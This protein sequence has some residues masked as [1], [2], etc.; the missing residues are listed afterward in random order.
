MFKNIFCE[1]HIQTS[2]TLEYNYLNILDLSANVI[3]STL[4]KFSGGV[5]APNGN[6][7]C[8][9]YNATYIAVVDKITKL[10]STP[11]INLFGSEKFIGGVLAPNGNIY[12]IPYNSDKIL[13]INTRDNTHSFIEGITTSNY[14]SIVNDSQKWCGG[15][16]YND[17]IYCIPFNAECFMIINTTN[18]TV[19]LSTIAGINTVNYPSLISNT[20]KFFGG[21][22]NNTTN[23]INCIH[24]SS[25]ISMNI[26]IENNNISIIPL[27]ITE[28]G[29]PSNNTKIKYFDKYIGIDG[30]VYSTKCSYNNLFK[31]D[32]SNNSFVPILTHQPLKLNQNYWYG[33]MCVQ[34]G[35][36]LDT[37]LNSNLP[38]LLHKNTYTTRLIKNSTND[39][40][41]GLIYSSPKNNSAIISIEKDYPIVTPWIISC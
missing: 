34:N 10:M 35:L 24:L 28:L 14:P 33:T 40:N 26:N 8:I 27:S 29:T 9:P 38:M 21:F 17:K 7:Y 41:K 39:D 5:L 11:I 3:D 22:I 12:C 30:N 4:N 23:T 6:I 36:L 19:D 15:V 2:R 1:K 37:N 18:N 32:I 31:Y 20:E 16:L 13:I 25:G